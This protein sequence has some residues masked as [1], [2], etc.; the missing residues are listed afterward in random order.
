MTFS[1]AVNLKVKSVTGKPVD[2][3]DADLLRLI[4]ADVKTHLMSATNRQSIPLG[5]QF[6]WVNQTAG[7]YIRH[8]LDAGAWDAKDLAL[9]KSVR[10]GDTTVEFGDSGASAR[11]RVDALIDFLTKDRDIACYRKLKW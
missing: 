2:A 3:A 7:Q 10:E 1:E 9:P 11:A 4:A 5:L 6:V 8:K